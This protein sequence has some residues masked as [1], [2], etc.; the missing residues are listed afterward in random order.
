MA[1]WQCIT[2]ARDSSEQPLR[3]RGGRR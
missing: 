1:R 2:G 3:A